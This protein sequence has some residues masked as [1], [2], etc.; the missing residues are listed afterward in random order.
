M[1]SGEPFS[2]DRQ[3]LAAARRRRAR[4]GAGGK[5]GRL[6]KARSVRR[7]VVSPQAR[8]ALRAPRSVAKGL[9][10]RVAG[11]GQSLNVETYFQPVPH[12]RL[13]AVWDR[14][15]NRNGLWSARKYQVLPH[16]GHT[17]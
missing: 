1:R 3:K 15:M 4:L 17:R 2:H 11:Q 9:A 10:H 12:E 14:R 5:G 16:L 6:Q 8:G 13:Y 7:G